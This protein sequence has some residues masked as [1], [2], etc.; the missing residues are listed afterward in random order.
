MILKT[1]E[2]VLDAATTPDRAPDLKRLAALQDNRIEVD[3]D[4]GE[5][6]LSGLSGIEAEHLLRRLWSQ[7]YRQTAIDHEP[8]T[9]FIVRWQPPGYRTNS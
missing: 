2:I 8:G 6:C 9:G 4:T 3:C 1:G 5:H 7:G